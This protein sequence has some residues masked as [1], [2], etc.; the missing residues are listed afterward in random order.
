MKRILFI[1]NGAK[2]QSKKLQR[3]LTFFSNQAFFS[4]VEVVTTRYSGHATIIANEKSATCDYII[5][6]GGDGTLNEVINGIDLS[7]KVVI[8]LLPYGTGNDFSRGQQLQCDAHF[9][10]DLI[11]NDSYKDIDLGLVTGLDQ[12]TALAKRFI[13]VADIGLG[14]FVTQA[15]LKQNTRFLPGKIK[16]ALAILRG[17][18]QYT[19]QEL[20]V[21]GDYIFAGK[22][23]TLAICNG[24]Y[25][26]Y[27]LCI[28]PKANIHSNVL[29]MT[30]IGNVSLLDYFK[31]LG[32]IK[33]GETIRHPQVHYDTVRS[34]AVYHE[35]R[36]CPVE[37]D[38]EFIG[39]TPVRI[40]I[41]PQKL[42]FLLPVK[43]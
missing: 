17:M 6:I 8:G 12:E 29:N 35:N 38:G 9:L 28:A 23:L 16:Y 19:K 10:F 39:H 18:V 27:G 24:P 3:I 36:P 31:H 1:V 5:A 34:I 4:K 20:K 43:E 21:E 14:G 37:I 13:N 41:L 33:R 7:S 30:N 25:F 42:K 15:I 2:R 40:Q 11:R 32:S 22:I 26:G